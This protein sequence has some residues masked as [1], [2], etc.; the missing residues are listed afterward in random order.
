VNHPG[1]SKEIKKY[2]VA[3]ISALN[4]FGGLSYRAPPSA[5]TV[6]DRFVEISQQ[7]S[8]HVS[9]GLNLIR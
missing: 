9:D 2:L 8:K 7:E 4:F 3:D 1:K 5:C 6:V